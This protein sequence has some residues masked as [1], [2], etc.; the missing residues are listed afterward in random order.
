MILIL[1]QT[2]QQG[3]KMLS[4]IN[5]LFVLLPLAFLLL[6]TKSIHAENRYVFPG[7]II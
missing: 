5:K 7:D 2:M 1:L 6:M 3:K 4:I